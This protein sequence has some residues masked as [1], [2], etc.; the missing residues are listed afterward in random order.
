M[1]QNASKATVVGLVSKLSC[2]SPAASID[3]YGTTFGFAVDPRYTINAG[4]NF[5]AGSY[6]QLNGGPGGVL[7]LGLY[8]DI[9]SPFPPLDLNQP[10]PG[11]VPSL[12]VTDAA[13]LR[14][15][16][17]ARHRN[18]SEMISN[19]S[20]EGYTDHF[21]FFTDPDNNVLVARQNM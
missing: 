3:F 15:S 9:D 8:K 11:T 4:G 21:F 18:V 1:E 2:S 20:D 12:I 17:L 5:G 10:P 6:V 14:D 13:A 7:T 19:T 16:M